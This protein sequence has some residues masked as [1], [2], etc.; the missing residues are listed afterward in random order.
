MGQ[1]VTISGMTPTGYNGTFTI[2]SVVSST[3]FTVA[4]ASNPGTATVF[5]SVI[6]SITG[7]VITVTG[8]NANFNA[9]F[10]TASSQTITASAGNTTAF[11]SV[12]VSA[13]TPVSLTIGSAAS[14]SYFTAS[15]TSIAGSS[16][17]LAVTAVDA[18]GN[19]VTTD[20]GTIT[21]PN[22]PTS[23]TLPAFVTL[24]NGTATFNATFLVAGSPV[25]YATQSGSSISGHASVAVSPAGIDHLLITVPAGVSLDTLDTISVTAQDA[26]DNTVTDYTG[27]VEFTHLAAQP[28]RHTTP[29]PQVTPEQL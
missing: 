27:T 12:L 8:G 17:I 9:T 25:L 22:V 4:L 11:S 26:Y 29:S 10:G 16:V 3:Q 23:A 6:P 13:G 18:Y 28:C 2:A 7:E 1:N 5:G 15:L 20:D 14:T 24:V 21:F 19:V